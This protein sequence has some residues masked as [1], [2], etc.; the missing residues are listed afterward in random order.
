MQSCPVDV[1]CCLPLMFGQLCCQKLNMFNFLATFFL[2]LATSFFVASNGQHA[3]STR[4]LC[5]RV[6]G[7]KVAQWM[8]ALNVTTQVLKIIRLLKAKSRGRISSM[9][10][11]EE[12]TEAEVLWL[13][14]SQSLLITDKNFENW[15][16]QF[17]LFLDGK[18]LWRCGRLGNT[19]LPYTTKHPVMLHRNHHLTTLVIRNA[20]E[21]VQHNGAKETLTEVRSKFWIVRGR[22]LFRS[23]I[24]QCVVCWRFEGTA[25]KPPLPPPLP[26][27][28]VREEPPFTH[29]GLDFAGPLY[30]KTNGIAKSRK[31]WICLFMCCIVRAVHLDIVPDMSTQAFIRSL[32]RFIARR[33]LPRRIVSDNAKT[34]KAAAKVIKVVVSNEEVQRF[35]ADLGVEWVFNVEKAPWWGASLSGW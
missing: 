25:Y 23:L 21:R 9:S 16:G 31:V 2:L 8:V 17:G 34:F 22:S 29:T 30:V 13:V 1:A 10:E 12:R 3:T 26:D 27:F 20:H 35:C 33:G 14:E 6:A 28:R 11:T 19:N 4:Q 18:G 15:K 24:F 5:C 7:N 32:K